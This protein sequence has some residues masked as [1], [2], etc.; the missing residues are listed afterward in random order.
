MT[1]SLAITGAAATPTLP[2]NNKISDAAA[3]AGNL[4]A[5]ASCGAQFLVKG[6]DGAERYFTLDAER[7]IPGQTPVLLPVGP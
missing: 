2:T 1:Y 4:A 6:P 3:R 7:S 5:N